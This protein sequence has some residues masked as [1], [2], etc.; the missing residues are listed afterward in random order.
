[1]SNKVIEVTAGVIFDRQR[2]LLATE[3]PAGKALA[4]KW[5]FPGGKLEKNEN[6]VQALI[7][8]LDEELSL[9][10]TP[11]DEMYRLSVVAPDGNTLILHFL[12]AL[13][14]DGCE[15]LPRENQQYC[16]VKASQLAELD[17]LDTDREFVE[18]LAMAYGRKI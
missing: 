3:R 11:L 6:A 1:M 18:Y 2:R 17:W 14:L 8:E 16:W 13:I 5:E 10:V 15:P 4:G 9:R 7:R 12:R